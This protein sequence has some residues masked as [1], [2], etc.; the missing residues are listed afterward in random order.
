MSFIV[1]IQIQKTTIK[2]ET[3]MQSYKGKIIAENIHNNQILYKCKWDN[4]WEPPENIHIE[5][6][7]R[8]NKSRYGGN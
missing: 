6:I 3:I 5:E 2:H 4:T 8:W 7:R 1:L